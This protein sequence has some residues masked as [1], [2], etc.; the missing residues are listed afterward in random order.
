MCRTRTRSLIALLIVLGPALGAVVPQPLRA[1]PSSAARVLVTS[2][3]DET[4]LVRL[5]GNTRRE[6]N[7]RNDRGR[8]PDS[9]PL[10][11][12][13]LLLKR[14]A[15]REQAL[16]EYIAE[17]HN[18]ASPNFH[19]WLSAAEFGQR[20]GVSS[21]DLDAVT[22]WLRR[23]G[24]TVNIVYPST[25]MIDFSGT[26]GA[27]RTYLH[28]EIHRLAVG[29]TQHFANMSDPKIPAALAPVVTG[30]VSLHD[31]RPHTMYRPRAAFTTALGYYAV[32]P[33]DLATIYHLNSL[34]QAGT[35]TKGQNQTIVVIEDSNVYSSN[36]L[37]TFRSTFGLGSGSF[38]EIHP[39]NNCTDPKVVPPID[40]EAILDAE[41]AAAAA[42]GAAIVLAS[43]QDSGPTFGGLIALE[44]LVNSGSPPAIVS[45]SY[46]ECEADLGQSGNQAYIT[47]YQQAVSEGMSVFVAA[48]DQGAAS[49]DIDT[50]P[51]PTAPFSATHGIGVSGFAST[52]YNVAVGGTDFGDTF[53]GTN[54]TYWS[55]TNRAFFV[56]ALSY[57]PEIPWND[58]CASVLIS[59][60]FGFAAP[61]GSA[62]YCSDPSASV[63]GSL[64]TAAGSGGP[65]GCAS[66]APKTMG[67][68]GGSCAGTP[69][70]SWQTGVP[71]IPSDGVRDIPDVSLFAA[72]GVWGHYF[73]FC[74]SNPAPQAQGAKPCTGA[75]D[76]W[77]AAGGTSFSSPI[78]A[79]IQALVN[80]TTG[81]RQ[82]NPNYVYYTL[83]A[84]QSASG[85]VCDSSQGTAISP[86]CVFQDVTL[87]D[88]DVNCLSL[89][90]AENCFLSDGQ[91]GVLSTNNANYRI[92]YSAATGWDFATGIGTPNAANLV[93][94]WTSSDLALTASGSVTPA[95][96]LSYKLTVTDRG[97]QSAS[98]VVVSTTL[99]AGLSL[100]MGSSSPGCTQSGQV[101]SCTVGTLAVGAMAVV[102]FLIEPGNTQTISLTFTATSN[103][104]DLNP[105][106]GKTTLAL[107][108]PGTGTSGSDGPM[109]PWALV[110]LGVLLL[111]IAS[112]QLKRGEVRQRAT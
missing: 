89:P 54:S 108:L 5:S 1:Q 69:K 47:T 82:G 34:F 18:R 85:M 20:Y 75:P 74:W 7:A 32:V 36:D 86:N 27:V 65:S 79:G 28:T 60:T 92:A 103:N 101:V 4:R 58:S 40:G 55:T 57:V 15:E 96:L 90:P 23:S 22:G 78:L 59:I 9:W 12:M 70:P 45:I 99:P 8:L 104:L 98:G 33:A 2:P 109:P 24:F 17:L 49:C 30:I 26:A 46:G 42:P 37:K 19:H 97:P 77:S 50:N 63:N 95:G 68:V 111:A 43:C 110:A 31:F 16:E 10:E 44:N 38:N 91:V 67:V 3:I 29:N 87:G 11:H 102:N 81:S 51:D 62:G 105:A 6:A 76:T 56:S 83:A 13:Q 107:S 48:G 35:G 100:V 84:S 64:T 61:Y 73:V 112:R 39:G 66:G 94:F 106:D 53:A 41:W 21:Q 71:G 72:N 88:I 25:M 80:Q 14:P 52:P 93:K